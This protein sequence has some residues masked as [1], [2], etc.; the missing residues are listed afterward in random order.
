VNPSA[1]T[2]ITGWEMEKKNGILPSLEL[3][4]DPP[5]QK[6]NIGENFTSYLKFSN[7]GA[8]LKNSSINS[9][10]SDLSDFVED[11]T[12]YVF[13]IKYKIGNA[14]GTYARI[15]PTVVIG[16]YEI[17]NDDSFKIE[18]IFNFDPNT[19]SL[20]NSGYLSMTAT[21]RASISQAELQEWENKYGLFLEFQD[22]NEIFIEEV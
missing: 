3:V 13:R 7:N 20:D 9:F 11:K 8:K 5:V 19:A 6:E 17:T 12:E 14:S 4:I 10:K 22:L 2:N 21:A 16:S 15:A 18:P 1:F